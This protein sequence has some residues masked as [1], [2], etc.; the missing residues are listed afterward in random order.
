MMTMMI[1]GHECEWGTLWGR[2]SR[3]G[4]GKEILLRGEEDQNTLHVKTT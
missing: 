2:I 4:E 3:R 1:V